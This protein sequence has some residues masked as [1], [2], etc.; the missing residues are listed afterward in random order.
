[1]PSGAYRFSVGVWDGLN[2]GSP[3]DGSA[4]IGDYVIQFRVIDPT[5]NIIVANIAT[6]LTGTAG[7]LH[8]LTGASAIPFTLTLD[9]IDLSIIICDSTAGPSNRA[10]SIRN[11]SITRNDD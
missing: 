6:T 11:P 3:A 5:N 9:G 7:T 1:M 4:T 8:L 2:A 10:I